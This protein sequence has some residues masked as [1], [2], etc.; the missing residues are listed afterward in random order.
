[1]NILKVLRTQKATYWPPARTDPG[2]G[3]TAYGP[4]V[5]IKCRWTDCAE[6]VTFRDGNTGATNSF[7][8]CDRV[9]EEDGVL[10]KGWAATPYAA[11]LDPLSLDG[12][13]KIRKVDR[14][15]QV[16]GKNDTNPNKTLIRAVL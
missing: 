10:R 11:D 4:A 13:W 14:V 8:D 5:N 16:R 12:S 3:R 9:V 7:V 1:M 15:P 2:T 6:L